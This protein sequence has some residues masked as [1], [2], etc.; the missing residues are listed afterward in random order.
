MTHPLY[1]YYRKPDRNNI[2]MAKMIERAAEG[3]P[4]R[5]LSRESGIAE[6]SLHNIRSLLW[7]PQ[8]AQDMVESGEL[9]LKTA[10]IFADHDRVNMPNLRDYVEPFINGTLSTNYA[11]KYNTIWRDHSDWTPQQLV[12]AARYGEKTVQ[13]TIDAARTATAASPVVVRHPER[14]RVTPQD[15]LDAAGKLSGLLH[16]VEWDNTVEALMAKAALKRLGVTVPE[17]RKV[18]V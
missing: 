16:T 2:T 4:Y 18:L 7:L 1:I 12:Q 3:K 14:V 8:W 6:G 11:E 10:R 15:V 9:K 5:Q 13:A 17:N